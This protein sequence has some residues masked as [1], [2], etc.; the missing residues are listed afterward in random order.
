MFNKKIKERLIHLEWTSLS[1]ETDIGYII[2]KLEVLTE[3]VDA[4]ESAIK[5]NGIKI[6]KPINEE[7][8]CQGR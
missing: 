8:V 1:F 5:A 7:G 6:C 4:I 2:Y 3:R